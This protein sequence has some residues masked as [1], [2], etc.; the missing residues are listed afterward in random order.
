VTPQLLQWADIVFVVA[1]AHRNGRSARFKPR[2]GNA[3]GI[4]L[5]IPDEYAF[6]DP[7]LARLLEGKVPR[8]LPPHRE[9]P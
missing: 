5:D 3:R 2:L 8:G 4:C 7:S 6:M 9:L 1:R